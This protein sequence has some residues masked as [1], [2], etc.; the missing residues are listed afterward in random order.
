MRPLDCI[1][2]PCWPQGDKPWAQ[3][4]SGTSG[5]E[6][7]GSAHDAEPRREGF[8]RAAVRRLGNQRPS[9][10]ETDYAALIVL[11]MGKNFGWNGGIPASRIALPSFDSKNVSNASG[12]SHTSTTRQPPSVGPAT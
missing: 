1:N 6:T 8:G 2:P 9:L 7:G 12:V 10:K 11:W 3:E 4:A 5:G